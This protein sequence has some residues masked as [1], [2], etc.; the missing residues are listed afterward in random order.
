[1][2]HD[3]LSESLLSDAY[4]EQIAREAARH[5]LDGRDLGRLRDFIWWHCTF[6]DAVDHSL[7]E[8]VS[9]HLRARSSEQAQGPQAR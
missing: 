7:I 4:I 2:A 8:R 6:S 1:M 9:Q 5:G 3:S